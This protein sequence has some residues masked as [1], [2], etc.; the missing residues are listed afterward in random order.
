M[1]NLLFVFAFTCIFL[2]CSIEVKTQVKAEII[3]KW[4]WVESSGGFAG[5]ITTPETTG[6][7]IT[8][9]FTKSTYKKYINGKLDIE[10]TYLIETGNSMRKSDKTD[11]IIYQNNKKQSLELKDNKLILYDE[12][13]DC[14]QTE[15]IRKEN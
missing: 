7:Q 6:N 9:E 12:C 5:G 3:G 11:L 14:F 10:M 2:F 1:K 4:V 13:F 8:I 15:Y